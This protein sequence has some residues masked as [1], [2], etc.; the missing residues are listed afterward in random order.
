[1]RMLHLSALAALS[2]GLASCSGNLAE[3]SGTVRLNG[4]PVEE[5]A[6]NFIPVEGTQGAG[7]G[8]EIRN[9]AYRIPRSNGAAVGKNRVEL[10][11]FRN[12]GKKVPDL[13][14]APGAMMDERVP[15]FPPEYNDRSTLIKEVKAGSNKIDFDIDTTGK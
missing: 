15:A 5:G 14:G 7:A 6:I 12:T 2:L 11:G 3:I 9:G 4:V 8:A 10:R 1:M 13:T